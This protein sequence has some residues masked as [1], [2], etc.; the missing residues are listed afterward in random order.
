MV[1]TTVFGKN[2]VKKPKTIEVSWEDLLG[3]RKTIP[4]GYKTIKEICTETGTSPSAL[5][6]KLSK[7]IEDDKV[8]KIVSCNTAYYKM[9]GQ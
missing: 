8:D 9:K 2:K 1:K 6:C 4:E 5:R 7:L 3:T